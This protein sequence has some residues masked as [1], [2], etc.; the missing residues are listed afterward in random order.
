MP[1]IKIEDAKLIRGLKAG[2]STR[3]LADTLGV[4]DQAIR[5][6]MKKLNL[7]VQSDVASTANSA[8]ELL[9]RDVNL[10]QEMFHLMVGT[11]ETLTMLEEVARG[12]RPVEDAEGLLNGKVS[13]AKAL[14]DARQESRQQIALMFNIMQSITSLKEV[15]SL[16]DAILEEIKR[17]SP[18][19]ARRIVERLVGTCSA[20]GMV[21][22]DGNSK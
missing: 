16:Q 21:S 19:T 8:A 22:L 13:V 4:T 20:Y 10:A 3:E 5:Y 11:K 7:A 14:H 18:E 9:Q 15:R 1:K 6:R 12:D 2:L 17:E